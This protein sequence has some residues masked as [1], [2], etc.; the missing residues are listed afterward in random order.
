M[1]ITTSLRHIPSWFD[2]LVLL[3]DYCNRFSEHLSSHIDTIKRQEKEERKN[4]TSFLLVIR[5][6][7]ISSLNFPVY[8]IKQH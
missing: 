8:I 7:R 5:T 1:H 3:K 2:L 6:V 4:K